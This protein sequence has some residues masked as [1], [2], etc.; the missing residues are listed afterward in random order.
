M[1]AATCPRWIAALV[2]G[3]VRLVA[4]GAATDCRQARAQGDGGFRPGYEIYSTL[5]FTSDEWYQA[6]NGNAWSGR[7]V[8][9][10]RFD[11][12]VADDFTTSHH[13]LLTSVTGAYLCILGRVPADGLEVDVWTATD[14]G[15]GTLVASQTAPVTVVS[16]WGR[17]GNYERL[18]LSAEV[19]ILLE[20]DTH[21][22]ITIQPVD[23]TPGGDW[24][25]QIRRTEIPHRGADSYARDG[26]RDDGAYGA[27]W[28]STE[29]LGY[30]RGDTGMEVR[31]IN[32][33]C[34]A[35]CDGDGDAD[36]SDVVCYLNKWA[37]GRLT[38]DCNGD[39]L[40]SSIDVVCFLNAWVAGCGG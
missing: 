17:P 19:S 28:T 18:R 26:G 37:R 11:L 2:A 4:V 36:T 7:G 5:Y 13:R 27:G 34:F 10:H 38:T 33:D 6:W 21:Y 8:Y 23:G 9:G 24:Y 16:T 30:E 32:P 20:A 3:A 12:Q 14:S 39:G 22:F 1:G 35:D 29:N 15:P 40:I 31:A 25:Y